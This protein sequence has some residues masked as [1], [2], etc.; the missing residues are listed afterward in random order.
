LTGLFSTGIVAPPLFGA[1]ADAQGFRAAW[2]A[3]AAFALVGLVPATL[4]RRAM[5][6]AC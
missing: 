3:L 6:R 5:A 2:V 4:A 1:L